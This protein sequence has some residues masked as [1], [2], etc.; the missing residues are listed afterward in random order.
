MTPTLCQLAQL[1]CG[2]FLSG[3]CSRGQTLVRR[4]EGLRISQ[5]AQGHAKLLIF[6]FLWLYNANLF[7]LGLN[8]FHIKIALKMCQKIYLWER[9]KVWCSPAFLFQHQG[10]L[11]STGTSSD[12]SNSLLKTTPFLSP[13]IGKMVLEWAQ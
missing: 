12:I 4:L 9:S 2:P 10:C 1:D 7:Y 5:A 3:F 13:S 6:C 8:F 11:R